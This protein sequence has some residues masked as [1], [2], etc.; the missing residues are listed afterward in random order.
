MFE[1]ELL[2]YQEEVERGKGFEWF[3]T[4]EYSADQIKL[5]DKVMTDRVD[6]AVRIKQLCDQLCKVRSG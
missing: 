4:T 6:E 2:K 3:V 5:R 1:A